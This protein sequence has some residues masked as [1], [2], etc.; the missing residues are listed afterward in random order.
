MTTKRDP[1]EVEVDVQADEGESKD[2]TTD[3]PSSH[4]TCGQFPA[5]EV[6]ATYEADA[7]P[8]ET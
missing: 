7:P 5:D 4:E 2:A 6:H 1:D 8:P 3:V